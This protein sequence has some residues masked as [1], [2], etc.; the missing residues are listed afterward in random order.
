M[1]TP[2]QITSIGRALILMTLG[3]SLAGAQQ[4]IPAVRPI[5]LSPD[6]NV[7]VKLSDGSQIFGRLVRRD[8]DS[9][10]VLAAA[11]RLAFSSVTVTDIR[12]AGRK[13]VDANGKAEYWFE[14]A[15]TTRLFFGPTG[16]TLKAGDGYFAD[17]YVVLASVGI[18]VTDRF[19]LGGGTFIIPN[20]EIWGVM[21]KIGIVQSED[22]NLAAG[23]LYGGVGNATGGIG[24]LVGTFGSA[25]RSLTLGAGHG[26][27]G[28]KLAGKPIFMVGGEYRMSR[29]TALLTENYFGEG[30]EDGLIMYGMRFLGERITVDLGFLNSAR[31]GVFPG[32]PYVDFVIKW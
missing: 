29:G 9:V 12:D 1:N 24:Y 16:R 14:N 21:P 32:I 19:Q 23:A 5:R 22:F 18:G 6:S 28:D 8:V 17:H 30:W 20:S 2:L 26:I 3:A 31:S 25:D 10:V 11:G 27:S 15:N 4:P 7:A 13:R